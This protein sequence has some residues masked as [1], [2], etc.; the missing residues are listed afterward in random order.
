MRF[1]FN[2]MG[3]PEHFPELR[4]SVRAFLREE[5]AAGRIESRPNSWMRYD[6]EFT[7]RCGELGLIGITFPQQYGGGAGTALER[8]IVVEEMLAVGAPVGMHWVADR[9]SG[10]QILRYGSDEAK[11]EILPRIAAGRCCIGIGMS[12][13]DA[14]SDLASIRTRGVA[15]DGGWRIRGAKLWTSNAHR[16]DYIIALIRTGDSSSMKHAGLTQVIVDM[17][18]DGL[19]ANPVEDMT[20]GRD[21]NEV[22]FDDVFVPAHMVLAAPGDG[23]KLVTGELAYERSGPERFM[24]TFELFEAFVDQLGPSPDAHATAALGRMVTHF[25]TLRRMSSA[26]AQMLANGD[27]PDLEAALVK[28]LGTA[29]ERE[30]IDV[31]REYMAFVPATERTAHYDRT[32]VQSLLAGPSFT[33]RGGTREIMRGIVAK[34]M[35]VV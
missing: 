18:A 33:L 28:D 1:R 25:V 21:F 27:S 2:E 9:Q 29:F 22:S 3:T 26:I 12:E 30:L 13:A 7:R 4:R 19:R 6:A 10:P 35:N 8:H 31:T 23:W 32:L 11:R 20:G 34:Q 17:R 14:G 16:A 15:C 24:S 5:L